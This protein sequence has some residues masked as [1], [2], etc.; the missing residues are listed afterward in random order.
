MPKNF[1]LYPH[2][3]IL[4]IFIQ[5][6]F[7]T[8]F[9]KSTLAQ[10]NGFPYQISNYQFDHL[11]YFNGLSFNETRW[12]LKD[13]QGFIW[14]S[15]QDGLNKFDGINF[16][17]YHHDE[18]N[19]NSPAS[20]EIGIITSDSKG[21]IWMASA[22]GVIEYFPL[23][24]SFKNFLVPTK[25]K[26][27]SI[28]ATY[29][30]KNDV[31]WFGDDD[32][33]CSLNAEGKIETFPIEHLL[34]R[35]SISSIIEDNEGMMWIGTQQGLY[36][37]NKSTHEF[38]RFV[39]EKFPNEVNTINN[40][41][42]DNENNIWIGTW[43]RGLGKFDRH[44]GIFEM[45]TYNKSPVNYSRANI[46]L[47][48]YE[49]LKDSDKLWIGT[50]DA[51]LG[52]F[53]KKK[54]TFD[55]AT[56]N[57]NDP[58]AF[59][60]YTV[61]HV[62]DDQLGTLWFAT[63]KGIVKLDNYLQQF[64]V[65]KFEPSTSSFHSWSIS[66][67]IVDT[68]SSHI[69][70]WIATYGSGLVRYEPQTGNYISYIPNGNSQGKED[71]N[72]FIEDK[73]GNYWVTTEN[74]FYKFNP[75]QK[76]FIAYKNISGK[77]P[78]T[79]NRFGNLIQLK[80]GKLWMAVK[81]NGFCAFDPNTKRLKWYQKISDK[82]NDSIN[83]SLFCLIEDHEGNIWGGT[84][85]G[86]IF[87]FNPN[88]EK[89]VIYNLKNGF[90]NQTVY[91]ILETVDKTFWIATYNGLWNFNPETKK[92]I[93][94]TTTNGLPNDICYKLIGDDHH[95]L[96]ITT[97]N[98][99]SVLDPSKKSFQN[100]SVSDGLISNELDVSFDK[101]EDGKFYLGFS[102]NYSFFNPNHIIKNN[103][104]PPIAFT[105]FKIFAQEI[106]LPENNSVNAPL[107]L[108][109]KQNMLSFE[110]AAL[111]Y[112]VPQKNQYAYKLEGADK[113]WIYSGT[114]RQATYS[115]LSGG[116]YVF[117]V[118][119]A[120]N[121]GVWN[122]KGKS[123]FIHISPPFWEALWFRI[124]AIVTIVVIAYLF[125]KRRIAHVKKE[126]KKKTA[127][128]KQLAQ[129]EMKALKA[130][131]NPHF[132]FNCMNSINSYILQNDKKKASDYLTKFSKLIR[133]ILENSDKQKVNLADELSML[134]T[135]MQLEQNRLDNKF[136]YYISIE[137]AIKTTSYEIP[138]LILQPFIE[139]AI[140][141]GIV[142]KTEKGIININIRKELNNLIC[143]IEDNGI[144]RNKAASLKQKQIIKHK[145]MGMKVT[146][147]RLKILNQLNLETPSVTIVDMFNEDHQPSGTHVEI[148]IPV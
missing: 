50:A 73:K 55:F 2:C 34:N 53:D 22:N 145:S 97:K 120:N 112:T 100:Y 38:H 29:I 99:L 39:F 23:T 138:S 123:I 141:H 74:G 122:E 133:L 132:I 121:D 13:K 110:F 78:F 105:S 15:T 146:E 19:P 95:F 103:L 8:L 66:K 12:I 91:S 30:D 79:I 35:F 57:D 61:N 83:K 117:H 77:N 98:G 52:I 68:V 114:R 102:N 125:Y 106:A 47:N 84:Q 32:G 86:G 75:K 82:N 36:S 56:L 46:I 94:Y 41:F 42:Q 128:N 58:H 62:F 67:I 134:E 4:K 93:H 148:I 92:F 147:D 25:S 143:I 76:S 69:I 135:Y 116:N 20:N 14:I 63:G 101:G 109:Y 88:T 130:Q 1:R 40:V 21:N 142:H 108:S 113:D 37:F 131:M 10:H 118:K 137:P 81:G 11:T 3:I 107:Q 104:P 80:D 27:T 127:F 7:S 115:N 64:Q 31:V 96:W 65:N 87:I 9:S 59:N 72:D 144:G 44:N 89:F 124:F 5:I 24:D 6:F 136:D 54:K 60:A 28:D 26:T 140:W 70:M 119:A 17:I 85:F 16:K 71:V 111:N 126:E 129:I 49:S 51:G 45:Y 18:H 90:T 139:N 33:L 43:G 48:I